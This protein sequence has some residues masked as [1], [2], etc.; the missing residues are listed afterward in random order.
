MDAIRFTIAELILGL[1]H[2]HSKNVCH[3]DM[4]PDNILY[5][6]NFHVKI[7]DFGEAKLFSKL[8]REQIQKDFDKFMQNK[9]VNETY[10]MNDEIQQSLM[11]LSFDQDD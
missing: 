2:M 11:D 1:E 8:N 7:C 5:D 6:S 9:K 4:K 3:R 10:L